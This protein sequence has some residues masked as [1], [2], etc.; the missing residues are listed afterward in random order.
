MRQITFSYKKPA[1]IKDVPTPALKTGFVLVRNLYSAVS[2]GTERVSASYGQMNLLQKAIA[3]PKQVMQILNS[4]MNIGI[5]ATVER[6]NNAMEKWS[7]SGYSSTG[8]IV[9][10]GPNVSEF[11]VG[12]RVACGGGGYAVHADLCIVPKRLAVKVP[13][14]VTDEEAAF[15]TIGA[16]AMQ[17]FRVGDVNICERV[18][19]VG[20]GIIGQFI[21]QIATAGGCEVIALDVKPTRVD[22]AKSLANS[23]GVIVGTGAELQ[24]VLQLTAGRGVDTVFICAATSSNEPI[25]LAAQIA[26]D[27]GKIVVVGDVGM[28][29]DRQIFYDKELEIRPFGSYWPGRDYR[30]YEEKGK[31]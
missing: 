14:S 17:G 27:R 8:I 6:V 13:D 23:R 26:R 30:S 22:F 4:M 1:S 9:A 15:A 24:E 21:C 28:N 16:V 18:A 5:K 2:T 25:H 7:P 11:R 3:K 12:D 29:L 10:V 19:V 20:L 31:E